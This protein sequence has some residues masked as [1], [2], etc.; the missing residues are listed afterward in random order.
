LRLGF[1][2]HRRAIS[3]LVATVLTIAITLIAGAGVFGYVNG[4]AGATENQYGQAVGATVQYLEERFVVP[5][6]AFLSNGQVDVY[7]YNDGRIVLQ[8]VQVQVYTLNL[9]TDVIY[10]ATGATDLAHSGCAVS[11]PSTV[12]S[13]VLGTGSG[14]F[15]LATGTV[16]STP[17]LLTL[18]NSSM[19]PS[20]PASPGWT[21]G[22]AYYL[23]VTALYGNQLVYYQVD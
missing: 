2:D 18:P 14:S 10:T 19:N 4:Q 7:F 22:T 23:K 21:S 16:T 15:S 13:P 12:E 11:T 6:V 17:L 9:A 5:Q 1:P 20:C 3:D 8:L